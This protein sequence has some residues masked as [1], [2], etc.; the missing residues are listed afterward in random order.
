MINVRRE[1]AYRDKYFASIS[2]RHCREKIS[3][4]VLHHINITP[5]GKRIAPP[6]C[7]CKDVTHKEFDC[8]AIK[9]IILKAVFFNTLKTFCRNESPS[10]P[11]TNTCLILSEFPFNI[12]VYSV[13]KN[14]YFL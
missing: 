14:V 7:A 1:L 4:V 6:T 8:F 11:N 12:I 2:A 10:F 3:A 13:H 9:L 5:K